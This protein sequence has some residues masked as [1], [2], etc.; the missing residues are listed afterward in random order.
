MKDK[1]KDIVMK[2]KLFICIWPDGSWAYRSDVVKGGVVQETFE[3]KGD[4][5]ITK[6]VFA[7]CTDEELDL[8]SYLIANGKLK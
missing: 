4:D 8:Y 7:Q 6:E 3:W 2:D 1:L 5:Y